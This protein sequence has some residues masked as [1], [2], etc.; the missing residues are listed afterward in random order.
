MNER[1]GE[2]SQMIT[3]KFKTK[4]ELVN[5][6]PMNT[7]RK[8]R[9][10]YK[11]VLYNLCLAAPRTVILLLLHSTLTPLL[12]SSTDLNVFSSLPKEETS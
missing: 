2:T 12:D 10:L 5:V 6:N 9:L 11:R 3:E 4:D 1:D 7:K 8:M